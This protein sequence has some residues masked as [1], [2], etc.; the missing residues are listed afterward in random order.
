MPSEIRNKT[1]YLSEQDKYKL[2][3]TSDFKIELSEAEDVKAQFRQ[4]LEK[5]LTENQ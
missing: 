3:D 5:W 4:V 2:V 1:E